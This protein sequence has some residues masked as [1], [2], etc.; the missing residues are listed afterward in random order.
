MDFQALIY[1]VIISIPGFL[2]AIVAHEWAHAYMALRY[3]DNTAQREGRMTLNP[4]VHIDMMGT[5][6]YPL[7]F[8]MMGG[9]IFGWAKPVPINSQN[10]HDYKKGLFW[11]SFAGPL[12]N[13]VL[14]TLSALLFAI[15]ATSTLEFSFKSQLLLMVQYSTFINFILAVFNL[16]PV[17]PF[18]GSKMLA[19]QLS[20]S[21]LMKYNELA[22]YI[23]MGFMF[24][25]VLSFMGFPIF[26]YIL[27]PAQFLNANLTMY[28]LRLFGA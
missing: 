10:F 22:P 1:R 2:F 28:F 5:V 8:A 17:P 23:N 27:Y 18:D 12:M 9:S 11:V 24:L 3:G 14:G 13:L 20:H 4:A 25:V 19:S 15:L 26:N 21:A 16:I 6:I 7:I